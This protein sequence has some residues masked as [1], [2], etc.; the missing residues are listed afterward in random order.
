MKKFALLSA[1]LLAAGLMFTSCQKEQ[2]ELTMEMVKG[3]AHIT[4][5]VEYNEGFAK[6]SGVILADHKVPATGKTVMVQV[7]TS[8]YAEG[9]VGKQTF[10]TTTDEKGMYTIEI[11]VSVRGVEARISVVPFRATKYFRDD[12]D[13]I[14]SKEDVL[15][16]KFVA[17][18]VS[19][20]EESY[21]TR[22]LLVESGEDPDVSYSKVTTVTGTITTRVWK[23]EVDENGETVWDAQTYSGV[24][25]MAVEARISVTDDKDETTQLIVNAVTN[26]KGEYEFDLTLPSGYK[27]SS[28]YMSITSTP[29]VGEYE[30]HYYDMENES[31]KTQVVNVVYNS[32][33]TGRYL[34]SSDYV[35]P[36]QFG[37]IKITTTPV[38]IKEV[39]GIGSNDTDEENGIAYNNPLQW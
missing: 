36:I 24:P 12:E 38:N 31:W 37:E 9:A 15:F 23:K 16:N 33:S 39:K 1:S 13:N 7:N 11:P 20:T 21:E 3:K 26:D 25:D 34:R 17:K 8:D 5:K 4:G 19:L 28:V 29:F 32:N 22:D 14:I 18:T 35:A 27:N 30:H 2:S 10:T 6:E